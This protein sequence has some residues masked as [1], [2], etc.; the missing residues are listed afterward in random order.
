MAKVCTG[1][2][3]TTDGSGRLV[4]NTAGAWPYAGTPASD[5]HAIYC[6]PLNGKIYAE[7]GTSGPVIFTTPGAN[8]LNLAQIGNAKSLKFRVQNGGPSGGS[9]AGNGAGASSA[10]GGAAGGAYAER[11]VAVAG[12][13]FPLQINVAVG[14]PGTFADGSVAGTQASVVDNAGAGAVLCTPGVPSPTSV[15]HGG[16]TGTTPGGAGA[17]GFNQNTTLSVADVVIVGD[18]GQN[19]I[20]LSATATLGGAGGGSALGGGGAANSFT[21]GAGQN[22]QGWGGGGGGSSSHPSQGSFLSGAGG[23]SIIIVELGY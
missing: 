20:R 1:C 13:T 9:A 15:G 7:P 14:G 17:S 8:V 22:G 18:A 16:A 19:G 4:A 21:G 10:G 23:P 11:T 2:G 12:L 3:L 5:G 6:D